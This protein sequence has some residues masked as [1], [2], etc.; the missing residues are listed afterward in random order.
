MD[1]KKKEFAG[2]CVSIINNQDKLIDIRD[3]EVFCSRNIRFR[4]VFI[5]GGSRMNQ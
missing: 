1:Q 2:L 5:P 4:D 3:S